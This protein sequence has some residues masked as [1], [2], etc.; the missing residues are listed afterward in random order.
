M[1]EA[2]LY[3]SPLNVKANALYCS[4]LNVSR[5]P[6]GGTLQIFAGDG[7]SLAVGS[8]NTIA[9]GVLTGI[10][11]YPPF[12]GPAPVMVAYAKVTVEGSKTDIRANLTASD[13]N[14]NTI[15]VAEAR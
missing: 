8:Y 6:R 10:A 12:P 3:T 15:A 5:Q 1:K 9:P 2:V 4:V 13:S 14:G 7:S 11:V